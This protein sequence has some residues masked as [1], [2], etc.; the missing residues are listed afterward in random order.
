[1]NLLQWRT[2]VYLLIAGLLC[3]AAFFPGIYF[4]GL[5]LAPPP[6]IAARMEVPLLVADAIWTRA[7]GGRATELVPIT[8]FSM[9]R[10]GA[11]VAVEDFKDDTAGDARRIAACQQYQPALPALEYFSRMHMRDANLPTSFREGLARMATTV[12]VTHSWT[13]AEF[14][15]SLAERGEVGAA[16]RGIDAAAQGYFR[17]SAAQLQ[18]PQ[19]ALIGALMGDR[20]TD[21]WCQAEEATLSRNRILEQMHANG[22]VT[23]ADLQVAVAAPMV[24]AA[25][26]EGRL[27]CR[28]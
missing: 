4:V 24:L 25:P 14:I 15:N 12:W 11:C 9:A 19:A 3:A 17:R 2:A 16:F 13:K 7:G 5:A 6:P 10:L 20:R 8:P 18:L 22:M 21:P 1:M 23:D 28:K 27:P 26:P